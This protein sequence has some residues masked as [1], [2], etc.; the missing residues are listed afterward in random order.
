MNT[1]EMTMKRLCLLLAAVLAAGAAYAQTP[2]ER[3][4]AASE[5]ARTESQQLAFDKL[6]EMARFLGKADA[7]TVSMR[8]NYDVVQENGEK[9][10]FGERR[11][12]LLQRP[13]KLRIVESFDAG[14]GGRAVFDGKDITVFNSGAKVFAK[15]PQPGN[16]DQAVVYFVRDLQMRLPIAPLLLTTFADELKRRVE[17]IDYVGRTDFLGE[18]THQIAVR[19]T[20]VDFQ[21]WISDTPQPLPL[22]V[23]ITYRSEPGQPQFRADF[24]DWNLAPS[25][26]EGDF[27]FTPPTDAR[28]IAFAA[29]LTPLQAN[30]PAPGIP[31]KQGAKP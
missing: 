5:T 20:K 4:S 11:D 13:D 23:V 28:Q 26:G 18:P 21:M 8:V 31:A 7:L 1:G 29:Q 19:A 2:S 25:I 24:S 6:M 14:D 15:A 10:E 27:A 22:R 12:I 30:T 16:I 3:G 17:S 9:I